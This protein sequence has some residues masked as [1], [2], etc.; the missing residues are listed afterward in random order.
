MKFTRPKYK[1]ISHLGD[2]LEKTIGWWTVI[3]YVGQD[4][5]YQHVY[6]VEC[7]CGNIR[8]YTRA[9]LTYYYKKKGTAISCGCKRWIDKDNVAGDSIECRKC[10]QL[11]RLG[12]KGSRR[13]ICKKCWRKHNVKYE[14]MR[15]AKGI[16][17]KRDR[18]N[19]PETKEEGEDK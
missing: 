8:A 14:A 6:L 12:E 4:L 13:A 3:E 19:D 1:I 16:K 2:I 11:F 5:R 9:Y 15:R 7:R 17:R 18:K 10:K